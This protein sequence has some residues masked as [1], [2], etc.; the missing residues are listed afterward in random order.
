MNINLASRIILNLTDFIINETIIDNGIW[1]QY[2][3]RSEINTNF[4][5]VKS[6]NII[7]KDF[8]MRFSLFANYFFKSSYS[9]FDKKT[10][11]S[12][13]YTLDVENIHLT[14]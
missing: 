12:V 13:P 7:F 1:L 11:S 5:D 10:F 6:K 3:E 2:Y 9:S 8:Y 4:S 14:M